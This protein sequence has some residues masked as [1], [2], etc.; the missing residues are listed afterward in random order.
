MSI[1]FDRIT[2][3]RLGKWA[4][5]LFYL[6]IAT[7]L[8]FIVI[9]FIHKLTNLAP[10]DLFSLQTDGGY[11]EIFQYIKEYWIALL[12]SF[13]AW[14]K[15]SLLYSVW[16]SLFVYLLL[17]DA[18]RVHEIAGWMVSEQLNIPVLF[19]LRPGD[20][21]EIIVSLV[22]GSV[23]LG[24]IVGTYRWSDRTAKKASKILILLLFALA[25]VGIVADLIHMLA[26]QTLIGAI[27]GIVED[28]GEMIV[29]SAIASFVLELT[30]PE[31]I[32]T[33]SEQRSVEPTYDRR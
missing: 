1:T 27:S 20:L 7:D 23:F 12:F 4:V 28:G 32:F 10:G 5:K 8:I 19:N 13:L 16:S 14:K 15:K 6:F 18:L 17:D 25:M 31:V 22:I 24:A 21:G 3:L 30:Q 11:S 2:Q 9:H 26:R 33:P 29:M